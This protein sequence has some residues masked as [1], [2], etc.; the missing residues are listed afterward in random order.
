MKKLFSAII[1]ASVTM[2]CV[3]ANRVDSVWIKPDIKDGAQHLQIAYSHD[4]KH[5]THVDYTIF[6]SDYG[7][8]GSEKKMWYPNIFFDGKQFKA[9]FI[10]NLKAKEV[11]RT[12]SDNLVL[13]KPQDYEYVENQETFDK[14]VENAKADWQKPIRVPY[15]YIEKLIVRKSF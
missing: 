1:L 14:I 10:P 4:K 12:V 9:Y 2:L 8:W 11:G 5:W 6:S 3:H 15:N 13:W 7:A